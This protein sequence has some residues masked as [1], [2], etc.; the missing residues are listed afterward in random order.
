MMVHSRDALHSLEKTLATVGGS[1]SLF[2]NRL[3]HRM[4]EV[5]LPVPNTSWLQLHGLEP[6]QEQP[7][8]Q[9]QNHQHHNHQPQ[10]L[11][12][13]I[14]EAKDDGEEEHQQVGAATRSVT[15]LDDM[16]LSG[17][18]GHNGGGASSAAVFELDDAVLEQLVAGS[19]A[20]D[21]S[22]Y[23]ASPVDEF[24]PINGPRGWY[25]MTGLNTA[26]MAK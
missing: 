24:G 22:L 12:R 9:L 26:H 5:Q 20:G 13:R 23:D 4:A 16:S 1:E 15:Y 21:G 11:P 17:T 6:R 10:P 18:G 2:L 19:M 3:R 14:E 8:L 7:Q 25:G